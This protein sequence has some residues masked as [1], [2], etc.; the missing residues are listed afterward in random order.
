VVDPV[1]AS[2]AAAADMLRRLKKSAASKAKTAEAAGGS[3]QKSQKGPDERQPTGPEDASRLR[4][5]VSPSPPQILKID[6]TRVKAPAAV[7][8]E[9]P[10]SA[11]PV[12]SWEDAAFGEEQRAPTN[13]ESWESDAF[14]FTDSAEKVSAGA[15]QVSPVLP[16]GAFDIADTDVVATDAPA[17]GATDAPAEGATDAPADGIAA[18]NEDTSSEKVVE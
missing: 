12:S 18:D 9:P 11:A 2:A 1:A 7:V 15:A 16:D 14:A 13:V 4:V 5:P 8:V 3:A 6:A 10:V 17:E